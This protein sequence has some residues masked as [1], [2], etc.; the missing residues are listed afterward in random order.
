MNRK[1]LEDESESELEFVKNEPPVKPRKD[2]L[3][4][5]KQKKEKRKPVP[6]KKEPSSSHPRGVST[7]KNDLKRIEK[8][9]AR[10][11]KAE[12]QSSSS[13]SD[14]TSSSN[15]SDLSSSDEY[16]D[17]NVTIEFKLNEAKHKITGLEPTKTLEVN[18]QTGKINKTD[19]PLKE[20][21]TEYVVEEGQSYL[22]VEK[23]NTGN[24]YNYNWREEYERRQEILQ[25]DRNYKFLVLLAGKVNT[26][27]E[28]LV[29]EEDK[30]AIFRRQRLQSQIQSQTTVDRTQL[31]LLLKERQDDLANAESA[32]K[33]EKT[34]GILDFFNAELDGRPKK[35]NFEDI[36]TDLNLW[37]K[38]TQQYV[39]Y[40]MKVMTKAILNSQTVFE[41]DGN[42]KKTIEKN[43]Q[44][45]IEI[46]LEQ[47]GGESLDDNS[48]TKDSFLRA[49]ANLFDKKDIKDL[50]AL[51]TELKTGPAPNKVIKINKK[52]F[53]LKDD[54]LPGLIT[55]V[56]LQIDGKF[57]YEY[58]S[59][60]ENLDLEHKIWLHFKP[61]IGKDDVIKPEDFFLVNRA[62]GIETGK[63]KFVYKLSNK[64]AL[65]KEVVTVD[66]IHNLGNNQSLFD[67]FEINNLDLSEMKDERA[68]VGPLTIA[69]TK[70]IKRHEENLKKLEELRSKI[71][72]DVDKLNQR[73]VNLNTGKVEIDRQPE[74]PYEHTLA[75]LRNPINSGVLRPHPIVISG[76][77]AAYTSMCQRIPWVTNNRSR[78]PIDV[79]VFQTDDY[80]M[81][82]FASLVAS[83]MAL[84]ANAYPKKYLQLG[85]R[86]FSKQDRIKTL[87]AIRDNFEPVFDDK[88][89]AIASFKLLT[90]DQRVKKQ[91]MKRE[92]TASSW[93]L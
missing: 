84:V 19:L 71:K 36:R 4:P 39:K 78:K 10:K 30:N 3:P 89:K 48:P 61:S 22:Q 28:S 58:N 46:I 54:V 12:V 83:E 11:R 92:Q 82:S 50:N 42:L 79:E 5:I 70:I 66:D 7:S 93:L 74:L 91:K 8:N 41:S 53:F 69:V 65:L 56:P 34:S 60:F 14:L 64:S 9:A 25:Q 20:D 73:L 29:E 40:S 77:S 18:P 26:S 27:L 63:W 76:I 38:M 24:R 87:M 68:N 51:E 57:V 6:E 47:Y 13:E 88:T 32:F 1:L 80:M 81:D 21:G 16:N 49:A 72:Q 59:D 33:D 90:Y 45:A 85:L 62:S 35:I 37:Y 31:Y 17:H 55:R 23:N 43:T 86:Q 2:V 75:W 44:L 15:E 67:D 52:D